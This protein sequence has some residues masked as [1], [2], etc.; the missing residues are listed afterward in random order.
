MA[1]NTGKL[2]VNLDSKVVPVKN[3]VGHSREPRW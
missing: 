2:V 1:G 3:V